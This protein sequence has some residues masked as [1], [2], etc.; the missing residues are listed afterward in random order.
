MNEI[1]D[2][3]E[4]E[5]LRER[6]ELVGMLARYVEDRSARD[7]YGRD[8]EKVAGL[9]KSWLNLHSEEELA[10]GEHGIVARL[11]ERHGTDIYETEHMDKALILALHKANCLI[12]NSAMIKALPVG[13]LRDAV[14][15]YVRPG[16]VTVALDVKETK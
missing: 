12:V 8:V 3:I 9:L 2:E 14:S 10:D 4:Q 16:L 13:S 7:G 6:R 1:A 5:E 11:Q 15:K